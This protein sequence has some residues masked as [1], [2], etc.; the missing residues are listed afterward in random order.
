[1]KGRKKLHSIAE[2][3]HEHCGDFDLIV[4]SP[5]VRAKQSAEILAEN[6][7][8]CEIRECVELVPHST[9]IAFI[10]WVRAHIKNQTKLIVVGHEPHLSFLVSHLLCGGDG[11]F[12]EMKKSGSALLEV[13]SLKELTAGRACLR[14]LLPPKVLDE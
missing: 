10:K 2:K 1:M 6:L 7:G 3:I 13:D 11:N 4:S 14:W 8:K 9:A 12:I 5:Y